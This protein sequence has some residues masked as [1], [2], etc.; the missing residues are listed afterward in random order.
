MAERLTDKVVKE[1]PAPPSGNRI[2]Y[3]A[4]LPGFGIRVTGAGA[5]AFILNYRTGG[6]ERRITI[7]QYPAWNA[8][9]ARTKA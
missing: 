4:D 7:G 9:A 8:R 1:L 2:T 3:D 6:R 5:R